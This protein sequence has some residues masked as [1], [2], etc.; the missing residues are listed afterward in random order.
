MKVSEQF[1]AVFQRRMP[2][3]C[4]DPGMV[5]ILCVICD[6]KIDKAMLDLGASINVLPYSLY[7]S[8]GLGPLHETRI[9]VQL[10]NRSTICPRGVV[11]DVLVMVD[12]VIFPAD[13]FVLDME[14]DDHAAP[15]LLGRP[16]IKLLGQRLIVL[17]KH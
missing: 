1:S 9:V 11:E 13:F 8:L 5:T 2:K 10:A 17:L 6:I 3:K 4:T 16:F 15:I 14:H 7:K 12:N